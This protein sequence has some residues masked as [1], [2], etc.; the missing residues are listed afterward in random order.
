MSVLK[1]I[2]SLA[3]CPDNDDQGDIGLI[4][5]A[6][7]VWEAGKIV[8]VGNEAGLPAEYSNFDLKGVSLIIFNF[9]NA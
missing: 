2:K 8:W 9:Y 1:N 4:D 6:A 5:G 7:L 3:V